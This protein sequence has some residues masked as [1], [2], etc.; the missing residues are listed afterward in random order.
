M[1]AG[2]RILRKAVP[3]TRFDVAVLGAGPAGVMAAARASALGA[4]TVLLASDDF[5][6]MAAN[7]GPVPVR[8]LAQAA[9]LLRDAGQ[10]PRYGVAKIEPQLDYGKV[11]SRVDAVIG[12]VRASSFL[13][14]A[15]REAG[16]ELLENVGRTRFLDGG[17]VQTD[18]GL[19]VAA[20]TFIVCTG[21]ISKTLP[22]PGFEFTS[23]H[24]DAWD[25]TAVPTSM[26]VVGAGATGLQVASVFH[27]FGTRV[28]LLEVG[29]RLLP[30][31]DADVATALADRFDAMGIDVRV[32]FG[33]V[34]SFE[35]TE[36]GVAIHMISGAG[37]SALEA[38]LVVVAV[39]WTTDISALHLD[40]AGVETTERGFIGV[41][42]Y[43]RTSNPNVFAAGDVTGRVM[44][45]SEAIR[46]G[47]IAAT[48]A[49]R[50]PSVVNAPHPV[51]SGSFTDPEYASVG[52]TE[53]E[54]RRDREIH[55][56]VLDY[57]DC[58]R[59]IIDGQTFG[60]CKMVVDVATSELLGC[61]IV[62]DR[63]VDIV[64]VVTV[65]MAA[66]MRRV[67]AIARLPVSFPTYAEIVV[68]TAALAARRLGLDAGWQ[69]G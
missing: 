13:L 4:R 56:T 35:R 11:L 53:E 9:R 58:T 21:G 47:Y 14:P 48:N 60:F 18:S 33:S 38:D 36:S 15:L 32:A 28:H 43:Q 37:R 3:V 68:Q 45:A 67:D 46:D 66:G 2:V 42:E 25:L 41:D 8:T 59:P 22:I 31:A 1:L 50:G 26:I 51:P 52:L 17:R 62:G 20:D 19:T 23:T 55:C 30:T 16:V 61:H 44:L 63:A 27:A 69:V 24:S 7:D 49:V 29:P 34:E 5:G 54:A 12:D 64:Q 65:A 39:G 10:L 57:R 40:S 6:G